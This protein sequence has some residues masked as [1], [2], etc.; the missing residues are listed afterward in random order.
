MFSDFKVSSVFC[1]CQIMF[2]LLIHKEGQAGKLQ[3]LGCG[4]F[5]K[6]IAT[7][8]AANSPA[9]RFRGPSLC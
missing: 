6:F 5:A 2:A 7:S 4:E 3:P 8:E 9:A 1:K